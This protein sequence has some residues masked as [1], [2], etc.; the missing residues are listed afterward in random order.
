MSS[1]SDSTPETGPEELREALGQ[2]LANLSPE[3][4]ALLERRLLARR[5]DREPPAITPQASGE[6]APLSFVQ[7]LMWLLHE[8]TPGTHAY[9]SSGAR[10]LRGNL[11]VDSLERAL[12]G[13][14]SAIRRCARASTSATASPSRSSTRRRRSRSR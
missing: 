12:S 4:Q 8:M 7:E 5:A 3:K 1:P 10:R 6:T 13:S 14:C 11:D 2:R 9:N